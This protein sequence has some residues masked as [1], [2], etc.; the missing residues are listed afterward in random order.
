MNI[1]H[2]LWEFPPVIKGGLGTFGMELTLQQIIQN[3]HITVFSLNE[4]NQY[5]QSSQWEKIEVHRPRIPDATE[6]FY[7]AANNELRNWG[8]YFKFYADVMAYNFLSAE[9]LINSQ[10]NGNDHSIDLIHAHDWLGILGGIIAKNELNKPLLFQVHSTEAGRSIGAGSDTIKKIEY[11][12]GQAADGVITVSYAMKDELIQLGFPDNKIHVVWNGVDPSKY[13]MEKVAKKD[14]EDLRKKY[15]IQPHETMIFFIGRLVTVKGADKLIQS[16]PSV[17]SEFPKTKLILLGIGDMENDIQLQIKELGLENNVILRNEFVNEDE[18]I[19]HYA[20]SDLVVLPS[21]YEPFGIVC[22]E[23]MSMGKPLVVG[24]RGTNGMREQIIPNGPN[25]SGI[26]INPFNPK[27]ITWGI[28]EILRREDLGKSLGENGRK[29]VEQEFCWK[30][31]AD[32]IQRIYTTF[33]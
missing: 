1:A 17:L 7:L 28:K 6:M 26:H 27:D 23:A 13:S 20:A 8:N 24:A 18:R 19:L 31:V 4:E 15:G 30:V 22:T 2:F 32:R 11:E 16:M 25:Q 14:I 21:L 29:R 5:N 9:K 10:L 33:T 3:H 12:G